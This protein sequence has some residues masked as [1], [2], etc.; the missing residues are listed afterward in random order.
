MSLKI[1]SQILKT[2]VMAIV[3]IFAVLLFCSVD[4]FSEKLHEQNP[5]S[6]KSHIDIKAIISLPPK[7]VIL[8]QNGSNILFANRHTGIEFNKV[9]DKLILS[10]IY[11]AKASQNFISSD[12]KMRSSL[13]GLAFRK[14]FGKS[15][16]E[17]IVSGFD[18]AVTSFSH[19][20]TSENEATLVLNWKGLSI[21]NEENVID[22]DV[23]IS[24][25]DGAPF[26]LWRINVAN[27][28]K[29]Y[30][31]W[32]VY[33]PVVKMV[34]IGVDVRDNFFVI[35]RSRG[36]LVRDPFHSDPRNA[37]GIGAQKGVIWPGGLNMQFQALYNSSGNGFYLAAHDGN[38]Y[39]KSFHFSPDQKNGV[40]EYKIGHFPPNMG[41]PREDY[42]M[43]YDVVL[44]PFVGNWYDSA[45]IYREWALKQSWCQKGFL[46][47]RKDIPAWFKETPIMLKVASGKGEENLV[48]LKN[49]IISFLKFI[50]TDLPVNWYTWKKLMPEYTAYNGANSQYR[51]PDRRPYP[52]SNIHDGN[53]PFFPA[54]SGFSSTSDGISR[55]GGHVLPYVCAQ[56]YDQGINE[57]APFAKEAKP[58]TMK[59][60]N[61][62]IKYVKGSTA[63]TMCYHS[64]WWQNRLK[65]SVV[66]LI[67]KEH[68]RGIYFDT[69]YGGLVQCFDTKHGH[70]HG[71][72]NDSYLGA[73][74]ISS[75]VRE[76]MKNIDH[77]AVMTGESPA[78][79]AIDFLDGF[80]YRWNTWP[81]MIPLFATVYGDS[82]PRY[83]MDL[84]PKSD[85]FFIQSAVLF[86]EGAIMG[87]LPL[88]GD[89]LLKDYGNGSAYTEKMKFLQK[90][91][92]YR[93]IGIGGSYLVYGKLIHPLKFVKIEPDLSVSY[94]EPEQRYNNGVVKTGVLQ[95]GVFEAN[96]GSIGIFIVNVS[97]TP[98]VFRFDLS[99]DEYPFLYG[100]VIDVMRIDER[101]Q[102]NSEGNYKTDSLKIENKIAGHD[103]IF[104]R[105]KAKVK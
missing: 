16:K 48:E 53:Y 28:S 89:D 103:V 50:G 79:T 32:C 44:G 52:V 17:I 98:V 18:N 10:N 26:S 20:K 34:P 96:D 60:V 102:T 12:P 49:R 42:H 29:I 7:G 46:V 41:Y 40:M 35:G 67:K 45:Q 24:L 6:L 51:V 8:E 84:D 66:E 4:S 36:T 97:D 71:G 63:W 80:L 61:G 5:L 37:F 59:D 76:A 38:G 104:L 94:N 47:N 39:K 72:G 74:R 13:W 54:L 62:N 87:R 91:A 68:A 23:R 101:G 14:D 81:D 92:K 105:I 65:D 15:T 86:V 95:T 11:G 82:I 75:V 27:R 85:G 69:M 83:G 70:S 33:F 31:L 1:D 90:L 21:A 93:R 22:V 73:K 77:N 19:I 55:V 3:C 56:I 78:E 9:G 100:K 64:K 2:I 30:G 99:A 57:N 25:K 58:N 88:H 43:S